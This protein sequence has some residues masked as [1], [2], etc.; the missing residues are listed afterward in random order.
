LYLSKKGT[1][2]RKANAGNNT[3]DQDAD[4]KWTTPPRGW[5]KLNINAAYRHRKCEGNV[6]L[7]TWKLLHGCGSLEPVEAEACLEG[8]QLAEDLVK[9]MLNP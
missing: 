2:L 4:R 6:V 5:I 8:L 9:Y 1:R 7:T 3:D